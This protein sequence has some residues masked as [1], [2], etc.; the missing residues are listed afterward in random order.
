MRKTEL[1]EKVSAIKAKRAKEL[2]ENKEIMQSMYDSLD[3]KQK[4]IF[5]KDEKAK[6]IFAKHGVKHNKK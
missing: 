3:M 4:E 2:A 6:K 1:L 5:D